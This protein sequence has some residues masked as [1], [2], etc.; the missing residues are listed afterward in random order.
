MATD[1]RTHLLFVGIVDNRYDPSVNMVA[2]RVIEVV[3]SQLY[4][5]IRVLST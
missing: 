2:T 3:T 5:I 4:I 1:V